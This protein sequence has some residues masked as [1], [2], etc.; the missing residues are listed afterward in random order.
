MFLAPPRAR[1]QS[2]GS[3]FF[4][5]GGGTIALDHAY[6]PEHLSVRF[7]DSDGRYDPGAIARIRHFFRSRSDGREGEVSLRLIELVDYIQDRYHPK[8]MVLVSGYRS[9]EFNGDLRA[10]GRRVARASLH[11][12]G[13]AA[14]LKLVGLDLRPVWTSLRGLRT[15]GAGLYAEEGF[16]HVDTGIPRFWEAATSGV[17]KDLSAGNARLFARTE[18]DRYADLAGAIVDIH[19]VTAFPLRIARTAHLGDL[20]LA[21]EPVSAD[22]ESDGDC[23]VITGPAARYAFRVSGPVA[24]PAAGIRQPLHLATCT[25]RVGATPAQFDSNPIEVTQSLSDSVIQ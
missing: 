11:T 17:D 1:A 6:F 2:N 9:P 8:K 10:A 15:G 16:L 25:P 12:E 5:S 24:A 20:A 18:F 7:R 3:R 22:A 21:L 23:W 14:D 4:F 19:G 13:L